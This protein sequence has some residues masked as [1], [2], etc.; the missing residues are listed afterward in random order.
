[1]TRILFILFLASALFLLPGLGPIDGPNGRYTRSMIE[2]D[3]N[4]AYTYK[5]NLGGY[6]TAGKIICLT[7]SG[8]LLILL[9]R[10]RVRE[11]W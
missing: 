11:G 10:G 8:L 4:S 7:S 2:E 5:H 1:M 9:V 3:E 6:Y